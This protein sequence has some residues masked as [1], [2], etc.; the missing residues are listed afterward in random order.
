M[1]ESA[2]DRLVLGK[3]SWT[4]NLS[5]ARTPDA[6]AVRVKFVS[7]LGAARQSGLDCEGRLA[8]QGATSSR[9]YRTRSLVSTDSCD[10]FILARLTWLQSVAQP[11]TPE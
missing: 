3:T 7:A 5:A 6:G 11:P 10:R 9:I 4:K 8:K 2:A 1:A